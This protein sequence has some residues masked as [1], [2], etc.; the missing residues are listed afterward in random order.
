AFAGLVTGMVAVLVSPPPATDAGLKVFV[1]VKPGFVEPTARVAT[2][3][4]SGSVAA[5][6]PGAWMP[7]WV[8][9]M[10]ARL[11]MLTLLTPA[12]TRTGIVIVVGASPGAIARLRVQVTRVVPAGAP[13]G[14]SWVVHVEPSV[15]GGP[16]SR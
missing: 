13:T 4:H 5:G 6:A 3:L 12:F 11:L 15:P 9:V 2:L 14:F 1:M 10:Q 7:G 16:A 8:A